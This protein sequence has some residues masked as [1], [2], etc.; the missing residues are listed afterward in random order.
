MARTRTEAK[1]TAILSAAQRAFATRD[2]HEV[3]TDDIAANAGIGKATLYRYFGTKEDLYFAALVEAFG[4]LDR[5]LESALP[6][7]P[8]P[9]ARLAVIAREVLRI[10][11]NR[12]AFYTL[13]HPDARRFG[14]QDRTLQLRRE[15]VVRTIEETLK[16]GIER[17]DFHL[18]DAR[19]GAEL[20]MGMVRATLFYRRDAG[21]PSELAKE[22]VAVFLHGVAR[23]ASVDAQ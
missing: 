5:V 7:E 21:S 4:D 9:E 11:W 22:I 3:L 13:R 1:K 12:R 18:R 8:S 17:G 15:K 20:F 23:T 6:G 19:G 16:A 2:F 14:S 10:F